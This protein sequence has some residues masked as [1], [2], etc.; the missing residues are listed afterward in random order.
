MNKMDS[1]LSEYALSHQNRT[2][3]KIHYICVPLIMWT[4]LG[5]LDLVVLPFGT[6]AH[7][8]IIFSFFFYYYTKSSLY[9]SV[10]IVYISMTMVL[11]FRFFGEQRLI[12]GIVI[13]I[14][15]WIGQFVGHKIEGKKPSFFKDLMFLLVGPMWI[16]K[17]I[18]LNS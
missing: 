8:L 18:K 17:N 14:L 2:N 11:L 13:F 3:K 1:Y 10:F 4:V 15:A 5:L 6:L 9:D 7:V 12:V 16:L